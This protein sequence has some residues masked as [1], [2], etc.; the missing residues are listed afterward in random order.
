MGY[1][2]NSSNPKTFT[3]CFLVPRTQYYGVNFRTAGPQLDTAPDSLR[4]SP[5]PELR[6]NPPDLT[7]GSGGAR[8]YSLKIDVLT[9]GIKNS[10]NLDF[11]DYAT[12]CDKSLRGN[13]TPS[14]TNVMA[15]GTPVWPGVPV[16]RSAYSN[17]PI[18]L[19]VTPPFQ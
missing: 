12:A 1:C 2:Y 6:A 15:A 5:Y 11:P 17:P 9:Q 14:L 10:N 19:T 4:N 18:R 3:Y 13:A 16:D 8:L 7:L